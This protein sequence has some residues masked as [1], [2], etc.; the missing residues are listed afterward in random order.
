MSASARA[1][2]ARFR[3]KNREAMRAADRARYWASPQGKRDYQ[4][5]LKTG[6][7]PEYFA[8]TVVAQGG[9][10][11]VCRASLRLGTKS[12]HADHDHHRNLPRGV[13]CARCNRDMVVLDLPPERLAALLAYQAKFDPEPPRDYVWDVSV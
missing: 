13:L 6:H 7:S 1:A 3:A 2:Q 12:V 11:A 9:C 5:Q 8:Q 4:R 10:C